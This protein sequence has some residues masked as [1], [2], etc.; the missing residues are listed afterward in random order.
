MAFEPGNGEPPIELPEIEVE[1]NPPRDITTPVQIEEVQDLRRLNTAA[2]V[3]AY[4]KVEIAGRDGTNRCAPYLISGV[5]LD[6]MVGIDEAKIELDDRDA[7]L[8]IPPMDAP[9]RISFGWQNEG[10]YRVFT[11]FVQE[12]ECGFSRKGGGRRMWLD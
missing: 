10:L 8:A 11:G 2:R 12:V 4:G 9:V 6:K 3:R 1:A 5:G 7:R